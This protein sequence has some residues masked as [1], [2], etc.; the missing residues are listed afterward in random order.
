MAVR[1][2][3]GTGRVT[4]SSSSPARNSACHSGIA[5]TTLGLGRTSSGPMGPDLH[6]PTINNGTPLGRSI[7]STDVDGRPR[8]LSNCGEQHLQSVF[9]RE[10]DPA[11]P[12]P[13][14]RIGRVSGGAPPSSLSQKA[15]VV[16]WLSEAIRMRASPNGGASPMPLRPLNREQGWLLPPT[17]DELLPDDHPA[18]FVAEVADGLGRAAWAEMEIGLDGEPL[19]AP[20]YHPRALLSVWLYGFMTGVRSSRKL[21]AACRDQIPYLWLTGWQHPDHNTLWRFCQAH[22]GAMRTLMKC[23]VGIAVR[24]N[25]TDGDAQ[26]ISAHCIWMAWPSRLPL[27]RS[28]HDVVYTPID[29]TSPNPSTDLIEGA[30]SSFRFTLQE[31]TESQGSCGS[32]SHSTHRLALHQKSDL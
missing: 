17:L 29:V 15:G 16:S 27:R 31:G 9:Q 22:R 1:R 6:H 28:P 25:L 4:G 30:N 26:L 11:R 20:A 19:G 8:P 13:V 18:R 32:C 2:T 24:V 10:F 12:P 23:T 14:T 5:V 3:T 7:A 21:E